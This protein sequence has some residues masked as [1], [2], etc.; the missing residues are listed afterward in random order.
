MEVNPQKLPQ[1]HHVLSRLVH[2]T[3]NLAGKGTVLH[4]ENAAQMTH[5]S[6]YSEHEGSCLS[7]Q[8]N[9]HNI[10]CIQ[11]TI[12][13]CHNQPSTDSEWREDLVDVH[14]KVDGVGE[15]DNVR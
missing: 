10:P 8:H 12:R 1:E 3:S 11:M 6:R 5:Q 13:L 14:V 15:N 7:R 9:V 4:H 2:A